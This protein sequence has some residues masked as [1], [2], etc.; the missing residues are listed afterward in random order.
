MSS[1][2]STKCTESIFGCS[3]T[4]IYYETFYPPKISQKSKKIY[5]NKCRKTF[6]E[7]SNHIKAVKKRRE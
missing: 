7:F 3:P 4:E 6:H 1:A 5:K 2:K